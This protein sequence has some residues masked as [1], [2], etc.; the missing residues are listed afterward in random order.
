MGFGG[1]YPIWVDVTSCIYKSGKSY[2]VRDTGDST[3]YVGSS[4]NN[5]NEFLRTCVTRADGTDGK[6]NPIIKFRFSVDGII[7]KEAHY[8]DNNGRAGDHIK[9]IS[10]LNKIKSL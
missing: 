7:L 8:V 9:T 10:K 6:G 2:G 5:S 3:I 1:Q 4:K